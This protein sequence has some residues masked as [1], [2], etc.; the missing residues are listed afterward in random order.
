M[1]PGGW[2]VHDVIAEDKMAIFQQIQSKLTSA[3]YTPLAVASQSVGGMNLCFICKAV[4]HTGKEF[5]AKVL[6]RIPYSG[7]PEFVSAKEILL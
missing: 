3:Q 2:E 7:E 5:F 4:Q 1:I 6:I